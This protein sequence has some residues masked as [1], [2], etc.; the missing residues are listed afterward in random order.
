MIKKVYING[1]DIATTWGAILGEGSYAEF[2]TPAS[3]KEYVENDYRS[4]HGRE[5]LMS[6]PRFDSRDIT[7]IFHL[8]AQSEKT[9]LANYE[10]FVNT[11]ASGML[12]IR[13]P[14]LGYTYNVYYV[15]ST[16]FD[17]FNLLSLS[18]SVNFREPNPANRIK[19]SV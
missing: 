5:V 16:K 9:L 14:D 2:L 15:N 7:A 19:E 13:I 3:M 11:L 8:R 4:Q 12:K 6:E 18:L 10:A 17:H 1:N